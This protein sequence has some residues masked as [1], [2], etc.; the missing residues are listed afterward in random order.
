MSDSLSVQIRLPE[1]YK[2]LVKALGSKNTRVLGITFR[3][4]KEIGELEDRA[5]DFVEHEGSQALIKLYKLSDDNQIKL[6][7]LSLLK[8]KYSRCNV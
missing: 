5:A 6:D 3:F 1:N 2:V 4:I 8:R 7:V